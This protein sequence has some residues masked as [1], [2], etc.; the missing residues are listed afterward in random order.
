MA[1]M[2][3][4]NPFPEDPPSASSSEEEAENSKSEA[5]E[6]EAE[7]EVEISASEASEEEGEAEDKSDSDSDF[8]ESQKNHKRKR[9]PT[10]SSSSSSAKEK[11]SKI[12]KKRRE[13]T[14][15][16]RLFSVED[17]IVTLEGLRE[18]KRKGWFPVL[19][20]DEFTDYIRN[21]L[22]KSSVSKLQLDEQIK[23]LKKR[24][25]KF[26]EKKSDDDA[27]PVFED[28]NDYKSYLIMKDIWGGED[29]I[30]RKRNLNAD[31]DI[32]GGNVNGRNVKAK[33][34]LLDKLPLLGIK[35][36]ISKEGLKLIGDSKAM[37]FEK[38][39][40]ELHQEELDLKSKRMELIEEMTQA[41]LAAVKASK[42]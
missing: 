29:P 11:A 18:W 37:E 14:T 17:E 42:D 2:N 1:R 26:L 6:G 5:S 19:A 34:E 3:R 22:H 21:S 25:L 40:K 38:N 28:P 16:S 30:I 10:P 23:Q 33:R 13:R 8:V 4:P 24:F 20:R 35:E 41:I 39:W 15:V 7:E 27:D 31:V 12:I 32:S 36:F 9:K